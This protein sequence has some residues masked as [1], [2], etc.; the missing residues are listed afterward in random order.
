MM[1][2]LA[3]K[4][5]LSHEKLMKIYETHWYQQTS[6]QTQD[7]LT[8]LYTELIDEVGE[9]ANIFVQKINEN[10]EVAALQIKRLVRKNDALI[11]Y[12]FEG[13][14]TVFEIDNNTLN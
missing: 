11:K 10:D 2:E 8:A 3:E 13:D 5:K 12:L 9:M 7:A 4:L 6:P 14:E 1:R